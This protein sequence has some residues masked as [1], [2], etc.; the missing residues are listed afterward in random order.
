[1]EAQQK[2]TGN[3]FFHSISF[4]R[5]INQKQK[6]LQQK[7]EKIRQIKKNHLFNEKLSLFIDTPELQNVQKGPELANNFNTF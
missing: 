7:F 3:N 6:K 5:N 1:L 2:A 4:S